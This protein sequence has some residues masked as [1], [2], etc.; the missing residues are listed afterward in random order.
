MIL[1]VRSLLLIFLLVG[2]QQVTYTSA[3][4]EIYGTTYKYHIVHPKNEGL[5]PLIVDKINNELKR[6]DLIFS[7]YKND[8]EVL[9]TS[10]EEMDTWSEDLKYLYD[11]SLNVTKKSENAFNP[12]KNSELD[13]SAIAKGYAVDKVAEIMIRN[14]ILNY[15]IE[16]GGEI[17]AKG[18]AHHQGNWRWAIE[19]PFSFNPKAF[20]SFLIPSEG[21][22]IATS[23]EYKN[24]GHIWGD[25][26]RD[27]ASVTVLH[28]NA[29][30][31]DAWATA[32]YVLGSEKGLKL[33]ESEQIAVFFIKKDGATINS[34]EWSNIYP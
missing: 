34:T 21:L 6:I 31:A 10:I 25:G 12:I 8:S 15:F 1:V 13:F 9:N 22:S 19:D 28:A 30:S 16:I 20:K 33:A 27:I 5:D 11:L 26:P 29:A 23:G 24:P 17:K 18:L 7:T 2:C 32:M 4:G 3:D 14:G